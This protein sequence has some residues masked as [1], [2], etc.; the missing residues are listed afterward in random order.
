MSMTYLLNR[1]YAPFYKWMH[2][3]LLGLTVLPQMHGQLANLSTL[4]KGIAVCE[5]IENICAS[6]ITE[7]SR[8]G[9][10]T[11]RSDFLLDHC[12][13]MMERTSPTEYAQIEAAL[14]A[15]LPSCG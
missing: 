7:L 13:D 2:R 12:A 5:I 4:T 9:L 6:V 14:P 10:T 3:G 15:P 11:Q 1:R 8:Q